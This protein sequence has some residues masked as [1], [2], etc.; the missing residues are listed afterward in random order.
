M[1][2]KKKKGI[3]EKAEREAIN[4]PLCH[5]AIISLYH[6]CHYCHYRHLALL[7]GPLFLF[8]LS[9]SLE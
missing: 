6:Y 8:L 2:K 9:L 4:M 7:P 5:Y 1:K 3:H